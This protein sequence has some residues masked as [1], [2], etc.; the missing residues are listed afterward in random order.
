MAS[1]STGSGL[2]P[3]LEW[4]VVGWWRSSSFRRDRMSVDTVCDFFLHGSDAFAID[5]DLDFEPVAIVTSK[6]EG[7]KLL[8][9]LEAEVD[10][11][12][13]LTP[14]YPRGGWS[15]ERVHR[16]RTYSNVVTWRLPEVPIIDSA[17]SFDIGSMRQ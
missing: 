10:K 1:T 5:G 16:A 12:P 3:T 2:S 9:R 8:A 6:E 4:R 14:E 17:E 13:R 11:G 7:K 15:M